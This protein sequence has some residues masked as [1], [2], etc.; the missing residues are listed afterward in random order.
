MT[1]NTPWPRD[2]HFPSLKMKTE[3]QEEA[4]FCGITVARILTKT[5]NLKVLYRRYK[6]NKVENGHN[7][8]IYISSRR[9]T[10]NSALCM[11][12]ITGV[13]ALIFLVI[14]FRTTL[15]NVLHFQFFCPV[16]LQF[17]KSYNY[18][19]LCHENL[20]LYIKLSHNFKKHYIYKK[21]QKHDSHKVN[22]QLV[23]LFRS[24]W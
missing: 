11:F 16:V 15:R 5:I 6:I 18:L 7:N 3:Q 20:L 2:Y 14:D 21:E 10:K 4:T 23:Y 1:H 24:I 12:C 22:W 13:N 19:S 9:W 8:L 17:L